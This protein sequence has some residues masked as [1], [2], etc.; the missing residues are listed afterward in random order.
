MI[1]TIGKFESIHL[2][3]QKLIQGVIRQAKQSNYTSAIM[4]FDP[5]PHS[6]FNSNYAPL[7]TMDERVNLLE[8]TGIDKIIIQSFDQ[9][10]ATQPPEEFCR[11]IFAELGAKVVIVGEGYRFGH[12]RTGTVALMQ[13]QAK[14]HNA[15]V[16]II[17][18][19][20]SGDKKISTSYIREI[21]SNPE[22]AK[23]LLGFPYF[24]MG[25]T[26]KGR[27]LGRTLGFPT[28]NLYPNTQAKF[29][30]PNGVYVTTTYIKNTPYPSITNI[31][32][33]PTV[34]NSTAISVETHLL[35][36]SL[37]EMYEQ[38][39]KVE[40]LKFLRPEKKFESLEALKAQL[41]L[42]IIGGTKNATTVS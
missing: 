34:S 36:A 40:F 27:Q 1:L 10:F 2:G 37:D 21:L 14:I 11:H 13:E 31:G 38:D 22:E 16:Q 25:K 4:I 19:Y 23:Q 29:L 39:I 28:L 33:R 7:F 26:Q 20:Q 8:K 41:S 32:T 6:V 15:E 5:H 3:H 24:V 30:P 17:P 12:K 18:H 35:N 9:T 42:D